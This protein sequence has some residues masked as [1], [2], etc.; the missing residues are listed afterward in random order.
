MSSINNLIV[1]AEKMGCYAAE[2]THGRRTG[3]TVGHGSTAQHPGDNM[4]RFVI[5]ACRQHGV[6]EMIS[7][8]TGYQ[9]GYNARATELGEKMI[10]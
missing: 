1:R 2:R 4:A 5:E 10:Y 3:M 6:E 8:I 9:R 7:V